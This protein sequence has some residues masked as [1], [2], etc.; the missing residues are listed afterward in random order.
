[1]ERTVAGFRFGGIACGLKESGKPDLG[2]F[3]ADGEV[4]A[5]AVFTRN[6]VKAAPVLLSQERVR[7]GVARGVVVNSGNANACTGRVGLDAAE[8]M[9]RAVARA[10][11]ADER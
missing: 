3:L 8:K 10:A 6:Q 4:A 7:R 11:D 2:L 1:M 5:A 9:T